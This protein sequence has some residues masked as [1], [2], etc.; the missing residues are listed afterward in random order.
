MFLTNLFSRPK[1]HK[2]L[3]I[4]EILADTKAGRIQTVGLMQV[5]PLVS[6]VADHRFALPSSAE[7]GTSGYGSLVFSN[8][9][10]KVLIVPAQVGYVVKQAAQDH[11]MAGAG[12]VKKK[13]KKTYKNA[14]C[15][16]QSQG[17]FISA[18]KHKMLILPFSLREPAISKRKEKSYNKLWDQ[19]SQF[20][21]TLGL[22]K[23]GHLEYFLKHFK[24][25]LDQ[26]VAEFECIPKQV[27]AIILIDGKVVGIERTPSP[28]FWKTVWPALIRECYGSLAIEC[29]KRLGDR[30]T[31]FDYRQPLRKGIR[32]LDDLKRAL[33][34]ANTDESELVKTKV[35][36][37]LATKFKLEKEDQAGDFIQETAT[38]AQFIGQIVREGDAVKYASLVTRKTWADKLKWFEVPTTPAP[39]KPLPFSI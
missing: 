16:Q 27:G 11:A 31:A 1:Q 20:N 30:A 5:I 28:A 4:A 21:G 9:E 19:I 14:M 23:H 29:A 34:T 2:G 7:V 24:K 18:D 22:N 38:Q 17:G 15:I 26:F 8:P 39:N 12:L 6:E 10:N 25:E 33:E 37:L 13:G 32:S 36:E 35:R 3:T